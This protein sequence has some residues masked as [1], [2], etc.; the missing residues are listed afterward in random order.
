[1]DIHTA[2]EKIKMASAILM[3]DNCFRPGFSVLDVN[4]VYVSLF[5]LYL[6]KIVVFYSF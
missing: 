2:S 5:F 4:T 1:M 6:I 3:E